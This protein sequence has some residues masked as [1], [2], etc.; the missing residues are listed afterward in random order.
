ME[1]ILLQVIASGLLMGMVYALVALGLTVIFG[2][3]D[4]VNFAHGE[5]LM[6]SMYASYLLHSSLGMDP[7]VTVPFTALFAFGLG[8]LTYYALVKHVLGGPMI[9]QIFATFGL[10]LFLQNLVMFIW[11][12]NYYLVKEGLLVGKSFQLGPV[13]LHYGRL[14]AGLMSLIAFGVI[15][16]LIYH[17]RL[18]MAMQ[19]TALD[20]E[21]ARYLGINT[22][23]MNALAWG[24]GG[25]C[26]GI[27]GALLTHFFY[28]YPTV[29]LIFVMIAFATVALG[30]FGSIT[31][32]FLA[33]LIVGLVEGLGGFFAGP[34]FK[35]T[36]V[37]AVYLLVMLVRPKGLL[38]R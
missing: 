30:G 16:W 18:G 23:R 24:I 38:G 22:D 34:Q 15:Y 25:A 19:A 27:A 4:I 33:G 11:G 13:I 2:V 7:L 10:M 5:F 28:V 29:G 37:Y 21:G 9:A 12:P 20:R 17:T 32:A 14:G 26:A 35:L 31:G 36:L 8:L 1:D 3:M 6:L